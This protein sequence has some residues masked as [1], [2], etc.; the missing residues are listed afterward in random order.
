MSDISSEYLSA[1]FQGPGIEISGLSKLSKEEK[2]NYLNRHFD[3]KEILQKFWNQD[4][5]LQQLLD[6]FSEN[7]VSNFPFPMGIVPNLL[8]NQNLYTV[9]LVIEESSVVAAC[10][11]SANFWKNKGGVKTSILGARKSGQVHLIYSGE[12]EKLLNFFFEIKNEMIEDASPLLKKMEDRGG[13]LKSLEIIF[14]ETEQVLPT[15]LYQE[16]LNSHYVQLFAHFETCDAMGANFINSVL[17]SLAVSFKEKFYKSG[18]F[19]KEKCDIIMSIL[20]NY[21]PEC[22]VRAEVSCLVS[23]LLDPAIDMSAEAFA[24]RF[25]LATWIAQN[26]IYR[27]TTHN[28]GIM[29][30]IDAVSLSTGNDFRAVEACA[31]A[32][33]SSSGKYKGLSNSKIENGKFIFWL[34]IPLSV[35]TVGGLTSL[36][37]LSKFSLQL[38]GNPKASDLMQIMAAIG[39]MQNFA[40]LKSLV[41]SGI[42]KGHMKMHLLNMLNSFAASEEERIAAKE[43]F[44]DKTVSYSAVREYL[45]MTRTWQ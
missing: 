22:L 19:K 3:C 9:P 30:G 2:I 5:N 24:Q 43:Y 29:N 26:D 36:H 6:E 42:Q 27:A 34:E 20:S 1:Q 4:Q 12:K 7:T 21:T 11:K 28:K 45:K 41:T 17:E 13:G 10:S 8:I 44:S 39:L 32:Y 14:K 25:N 31:H 15:S 16:N 38:M 35:G 40:A 23:E 37:P 18:K 33:A